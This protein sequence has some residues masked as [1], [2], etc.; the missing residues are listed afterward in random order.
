[1]NA[2]DF[3]AAELEANH[4]QAI[5]LVMNGS[6]ELDSKLKQFISAYLSAT[7]ADNLSTPTNT[8]TA[9]KL[10][11]KRNSKAKTGTAKLE[12][13]DGS[14]LT[15]PQYTQN[16]NAQQYLSLLITPEDVLSNN[17]ESN[18]QQLLTISLFNGAA[19][20][21]KLITAMYID[22]KVNGHAI[23]LILENCRVDHAASACIIIADGATKTLISEIDDL[24]IKVNGIIVSIKVLVMEA[25][26]YQ[27]LST[28]YSIGTPKS[29]RLIKMVNT[30]KYQSCV[31]TS[32]LSPRHQ[33]HL[34]SSKK[35]KENLSKKPTKSHRP[36]KTTTNYCLYYFE[37]TMKETDKEKGKRKEKELSEKTTTTEEITSDWERKYLWKPIKEPPYIP[38]K[39]KDFISD[40]D[41]WTR[42]HYYCK[43]CHCK[44]YDYPKKQD[45]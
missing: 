22:T 30:Y 11:S 16:P 36:T 39:C 37:M 12:I 4:A 19:L 5:N 14:L 32:S 38:L 44:H 15:N 31:A 35:K 17:Q 21:T 23:K 40:K 33:L 7:A 2:R 10:T 27:A 6:S 18:Q 28:Q 26:Q 9:T 29:F 34:S 43:P 8:D 42:I 3:K 25:T 24:P 45:K 41:Y 13:I 20:N 1:M